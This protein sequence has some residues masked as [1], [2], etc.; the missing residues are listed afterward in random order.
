MFLSCSLKGLRG[1]RS[2]Q[3]CILYVLQYESKALSH[4]GVHNCKMLDGILANG[5]VMPASILREWVESDSKS[6]VML[7]Q[8]VDVR[9]FMCS[10]NSQRCDRC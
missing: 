10:K 5:L 2:S 8:E 4:V 7:M 9:M 6:E 1:G 3:I